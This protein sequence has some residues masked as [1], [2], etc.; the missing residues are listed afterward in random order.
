MI[1]KITGA[2]FPLSKIFSSEF[3][4]HIPAYQRPYAW[5]EE[6]SGTLFDDLYDFFRTEEDD[7]YFLG[8]IVLIKED[9][10]PH[11]D[12]IDG[13]Q[14]LTTL[15]ILLAALASHFDGEIK[16]AFR[17]HLREPGNVLSKIP[18]RARLHLRPKDQ[19]FFEKYVQNIKLNELL[20]IDSATLEN[21]AQKNIQTNTRVLLDRIKKNFNGDTQSLMDFGSFIVM[22]CYLVVVYT[23]SQ[24]SAF[25]VF[26]VMNSRGL[27]LL[28]TDIVKA[29]I[30]GSI[31]E[32][33]R[34]E[35]TEKWEDLEVQ[36]TRDGFNDVFTHTR[37]I[38]AKI[39]AKRTLLEEFREH[40]LHIK[41]PKKLID[42]ILEPYSDAYTVLKNKSYSATKNSAEVNSY[43]MWLNKID[44]SDWMPS[45]IR[46]HAEQKN[47]SDYMLWFV[48]KL[49][50]LAS[51]L[52][53]TAKD[54][55]T[56]IERYGRILNEM[57]VNLGH[58]LANPLQSV[59]L[60]DDEKKEFVTALNGEIYRMTSRRRNYVILRL[61]SF[62]S[63]GGATYDPNILTIEH[64]LP[65]TV[66]AGSDWDHKWQNKSEQEYWLNRIANLVPL[67]RRHNSEAQNYDFDVKKSK[68]FTSKNGTSSYSLTT[69][70]LNAQDW[71]PDYVKNRQ[72]SL[73]D[74]FKKNWDL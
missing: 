62:V 49:E 19:D 34:D 44:N 72:Q 36:T 27:D 66:K 29:D 13:Q 61:D 74:T 68:Y 47:N 59:E 57:D 33:D 73:L 12:V 25:R 48:I 2:E 22:R 5:T 18:P 50:R 69:Q 35:Y 53:I 9:N 56:R 67:T 24:P 31:P 28:T 21:E 11:S 15:T 7:N 14:R 40:V 39:K 41:S 16:D 6:E 65:Q 43:L 46:F 52:H 64:V 55:N 58:S 26:S 8:S 37:M 63:A 42:E 3:D 71:T 10:N 23:A 54:I 4:Y 60:T 20:D 70:V 32:I 1:K 45:A 51:Y 38:Y 30:I 17:G